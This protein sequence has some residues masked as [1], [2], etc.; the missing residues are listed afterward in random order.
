[1]APSSDGSVARGVAASSRP[2]ASR[3]TLEHGGQLPDTQ[4]PNGCVL[5]Q[6]AL[7]EEERHARKDERQEVGD[8]EGPWG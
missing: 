2:Q 6:G 7:Q 5:A 8:E 1:M 3:L 4:A